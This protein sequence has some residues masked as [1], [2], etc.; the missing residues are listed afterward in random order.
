MDADEA[1]PDT[2]FVHHPEQ[3]LA[4]L[5]RLVQAIT[6]VP[7]GPGGP[8]QNTSQAEYPWGGLAVGVRSF[9]CQFRFGT[10]TIMR[11]LDRG[12]LGRLPVS[13]PVDFVPPAWRKFLLR[14]DG[15]LDRR[16]WEIALGFALRDALRS[17][18]IYLG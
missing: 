18:D 11:R 6:H 10:A 7:L 2:A 8:L 13:A 16:A 12:E 3:S 4:K 1:L 14:A 17:A 15:L 9:T 5:A